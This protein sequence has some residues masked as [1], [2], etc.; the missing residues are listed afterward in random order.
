M[1]KFFGKSQGVFSNLGSAIGK[2]SCGNCEYYDASTLDGHGWCRNPSRVGK[3]HMVLVRSYELACRNSWEKDEWL[4]KGKH[5]R[6]PM[7]V[8]EDQEFEP[9]APVPSARIEESPSDTRPLAKARPSTPKKQEATPP[10]IKRENP[11][12]S[13]VA[14]TR[15]STNLAYY[16]EEANDMV[17][18]I[19]DREGASLPAV[20]DLPPRQAPN[21]YDEGASDLI[22][23]MREDW[24]QIQLAK[25]DGKQCK[26]CQYFES[27]VSPGL[28][29]CRN[30][31]A[32]PFQK[33]VEEGS[34]ACLS[35]I[36]IWWA[37]RLEDRRRIIREKLRRPM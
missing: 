6:T 15:P 32:G 21:P 5:R 22:A 31:F 9:A 28:G 13:G 7:T 14:R 26:S 12:I 29:W 23:E 18:G 17:V 2:R 35:S 8:A 1:A 34:L 27:T 4:Q 30:R 19:R 20:E 25:Y 3:D 10:A 36:G 24:L 37:E 33:P 16:M 11:V